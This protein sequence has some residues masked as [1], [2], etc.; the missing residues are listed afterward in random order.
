EQGRRDLSGVLNGGLGARQ[1][2]G[3]ESQLSKIE[4]GVR[5]GMISDLVA[6][7]RNFARD[8]R[9]PLD[10]GAALKKGGGNGVIGQHTQQA[11][12]RF[13]RSVIKSQGDGAPG[14]RTSI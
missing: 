6:L 1:L 5:V 14:S 4:L 7:A 3:H 9:Q 10:I 2:V 11:W 8:L 12:S 13:A